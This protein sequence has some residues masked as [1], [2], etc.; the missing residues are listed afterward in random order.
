MA[1]LLYCR[2]PIPQNDATPKRILLLPT[3]IS[4][5]TLHSIDYPILHL[6]HDAHMVRHTVPGGPVEE[7]KHPRRR[8]RGAVQPEAAR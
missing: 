3:H 7:N 8:L 6:F 2:H 1:V 5:I 4:G